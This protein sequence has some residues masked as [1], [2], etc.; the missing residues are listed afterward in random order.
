MKK[1]VTW[2]PKK[3][4]DNLYEHPNTN[5][6]VNSETNWA[7]TFTE[8]SYQ[9]ADLRYISFLEHS[10]EIPQAQLDNW[11]ILDPAFEFTIIDET[12]ANE[13]LL[14]FWLDENEE[15]LISVTDFIFADIRPMDII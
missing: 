9:I 12:E 15:P 1:Y 13:L 6:R 10:W 5:D 3:I 4:N 11:K 8:T 7:I 14:E 2:K